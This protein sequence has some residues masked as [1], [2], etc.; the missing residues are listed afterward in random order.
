MFGDHDHV[1]ADGHLDPSVRELVERTYSELSPSGTGVRQITKGNLPKSGKNGHHEVYDRAHYLT[2]TGHRGNSSPADIRQDQALVDALYELTAK[3]AH[4]NGAATPVTQDYRYTPGMRGSRIRS[5]VGKLNSEGLSRDTI[6]IAVLEENAKH[7][8]PPKTEDEIRDE[9]TDCFERY[10]DQTGQGPAMRGGAVRQEEPAGHELPEDLGDPASELQGCLET[11]RRWLYLPDPGHVVAVLATQHANRA[12]GDPVWLLIIGGPSSGK[13][14]AVMSLKAQSDVHVGGVITE[15]GLLS[16]TPRKEHAAGATGGLLR[17]IGDR[18]HLVLK[19]FTSVL[20][21]NRDTRAQLLGALREIYDGSWTRHV[22]T[23]GA[24]TLHWEGKLGLIAG[25]TGAFDTHYAVIGSLGDR[26]LLYRLPVEHDGDQL[27][28]RALAHL[29]LEEQMRRELAE[30]SGRVLDAAGPIGTPRDADKERIVTLASLAVRARSS[31]ERD[32]YTREI[33]LVHPPEEAGRLALALLRL[34]Q[35]ARAI[36]AGDDL[37]WRVVVKVAIDCVPPI[38]AAILRLLRSGEEATTQIALT[39]DLPLSTVRR[40][41]EDLTAHRLLTRTK[42]N[43][44]E[45]ASDIWALSN[46]T[47]VR[48][49]AIPEL[50]PQT[51]EGSERQQNRKKEDQHTPTDFSGTAPPVVLCSSCGWPLPAGGSRPCA[52]PVHAAEEVTRD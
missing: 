12:A 42:K 18:G 16:A 2:I 22:G 44:K 7:F 23:D 37:A 45:G 21:M 29:G 25:C 19:D 5:L 3:K 47:Q 9:V 39:L 41:A 52:N 36:G 24:K 28:E 34:L 11:F 27:G 20:S 48:I 38:R 14:E 10:K 8:D 40:A 17:Q 13:T 43:G 4:Q 46:W 6:I 33:T 49:K 26:F 15:G 35:G 31:V 30:A 51:G 32:P 50:S 1:I